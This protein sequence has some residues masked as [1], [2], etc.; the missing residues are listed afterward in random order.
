MQ[1]RQLSQLLCILAFILAS[2]ADCAANELSD[3]CRKYLEQ[4]TGVQAVVVRGEERWVRDRSISYRANDRDLAADYI[5]AVAESLGLEVTSQSFKAAHLPGSHPVEPVEWQFVPAL[6]RRLQTIRNIIVTVPADRGTDSGKTI[7]LGAHYD[8][9]NSD[10]HPWQSLPIFGLGASSF[11]NAPKYG[12]S[13]GA[14]DNGSGV[15]GLLALLSRFQEKPVSHTLKFLFFD[16]EEMTSYGSRLG[17]LHFARSLTREE[18]NSVVGAVILD[19]IGA[20]DPNLPM[21]YHV[22][23]HLA[24]KARFI[25]FSS[26]SLGTGFQAAIFDSNHEGYIPDSDNASFSL[27]NIPNVLLTGFVQDGQRPQNYHTVRDTV[28]CIDWEY[29]VSLVA[30]VEQAVRRALD[31]HPHTQ[32]P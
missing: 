11:T 30:I 7:V 22:S 4:L 2:G 15:A 31:A 14:N 1:M 5:Q 16:G 18:R 26:D 23:E 10:S 19:M 13:P 3:L 20:R 27:Y 32:E 28:A 8:T 6:G 12:F 29:M 9:V 21:A 24:R 25:D 17:S